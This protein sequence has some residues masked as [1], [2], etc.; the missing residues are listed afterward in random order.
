MMQYREIQALYDKRDVEKWCHGMQYREVQSWDNKTWSADLTLETP[1]LQTAHQCLFKETQTWSWTKLILRATK[2]KYLTNVRDIICSKFKKE[3]AT[4]KKH[5]S[6]YIKMTP[7]D[8]KGRK[9]K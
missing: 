5:I 9:K 4:C 8:P 3:R 2:K 6:K 1:W 7:N